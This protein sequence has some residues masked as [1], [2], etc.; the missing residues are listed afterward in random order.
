MNKMSIATFFVGL[1]VG[2]I[3]W[4]MFP[5]VIYVE[6]PIE[7]NEYIDKALQKHLN[8]LEDRNITVTEKDIDFK[9]NT[10]YLMFSSVAS[11]MMVVDEIYLDYIQMDGDVNVPVLWGYY[12]S[13][14]VIYLV[15]GPSFWFAQT[16]Y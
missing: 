10:A 16:Q 7:Y 2:V 12:Q 6:K 9:S 8:M 3:I 11:L 13:Y 14:V 4:Q 15:L 1:L 5:M